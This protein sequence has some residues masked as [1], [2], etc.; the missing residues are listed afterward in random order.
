[1][2]M[3]HWADRAISSDLAKDNQKVPPLSESMPNPR[4]PYRQIKSVQGYGN[5]IGT[6]GPVTVYPKHLAAAQTA[7]LQGWDYNASQPSPKRSYSPVRI[8][9]QAGGFRVDAQAAAGCDP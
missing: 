1:M 7:G 2:R 8:E 5:R 6:A 9:R 3:A 4:L